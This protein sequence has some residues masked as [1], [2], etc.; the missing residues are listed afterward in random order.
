[1][2]A[3]KHTQHIIWTGLLRGLSHTSI[4]SQYT[5]YRKGP[6]GNSASTDE[7]PPC[8]PTYH[9]TDSGDQQRMCSLHHPQHCQNPQVKG[10]CVHFRGAGGHLKILSEPP[11]YI[12]S[13]RFITPRGPIHT[14][15]SI[16]PNTYTLYFMPYT[17][18]EPEAHPPQ[19]LP[20]QPFTLKS[21][22]Y[23]Y[24]PPFWKLYSM[25]VAPRGIVNTVH[26]HL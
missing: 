12:C 13:H 23:M 24:V 7:Q 16:P 15:N 2:Q 26:A 6:S 8:Q 3:P 11:S 1:M 21:S 22:T 9:Q 17:I 10:T 5:F 25:R 20:I 4:S 14:Y 19:S 18:Y